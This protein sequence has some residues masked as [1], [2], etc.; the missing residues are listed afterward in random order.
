MKHMFKKK[1]KKHFN[2]FRSV[3]ASSP[4]DWILHLFKTQSCKMKTRFEKF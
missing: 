3:Q 1:E 4:A 2:Y